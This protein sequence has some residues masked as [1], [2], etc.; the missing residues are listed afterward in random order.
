MGET[1]RAVQGARAARRAYWGRRIMDVSAGVPCSSSVP[2]SLSDLGIF[3]SAV[4]RSAHL[5]AAKRL[6]DKLKCN[7]LSFP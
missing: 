4:S 3:R 7:L 2:S 6:L 1:A 5:G